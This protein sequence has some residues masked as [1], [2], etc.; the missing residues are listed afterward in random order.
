MRREFFFFIIGILEG[1]LFILGEVLFVENLCIFADVLE[2]SVQIQIFSFDLLLT[3]TV[4]FGFVCLLKQIIIKGH[5]TLVLEAHLEPEDADYF[6]LR[7]DPPYS[8]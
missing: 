1:L 2:I 6:A 3:K 4:L 8:L 7:T 5:F